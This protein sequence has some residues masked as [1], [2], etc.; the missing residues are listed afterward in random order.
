M[1]ALHGHFKKV[2]VA[3][4]WICLTLYSQD[5]HIYRCFPHLPGGANA[6]ITC[7]WRSICTLIGAGRFPKDGRLYLQVDGA[8]DNVNQQMPRFASWLC[9]QKICRTVRGARS[10]RHHMRRDFLSLRSLGPLPSLVMCML[11]GDQPVAC[12]TYPRGH[13]PEVQRDI[14]GKPREVSA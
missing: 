13:R 12:W 4:V 2:H 6:I 3:P 9:Q 5:L 7:L 11:G 1:A 8:S 14:A 10:V